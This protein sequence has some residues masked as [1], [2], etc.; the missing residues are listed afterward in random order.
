MRKNAEISFYAGKNRA[1]EKKNACVFDK[2]VRKNAE[3]SFCAGKNRA[4]QK[5]N[6]CVFGESVL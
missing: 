4:A 3:I 1:A 5:K 6:A 2:S